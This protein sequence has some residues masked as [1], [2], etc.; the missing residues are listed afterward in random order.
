[1]TFNRCQA[2]GSLALLEPSRHRRKLVDD[3][4]LHRKRK[5]MHF[6]KDLLIDVSDRKLLGAKI[7]GSQLGVR[8]FFEIKRYYLVAC[9]YIGKCQYI[10]FSETW[11]L[12]GSKEYLTNHTEM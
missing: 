10:Y 3:H 5:F 8:T 7:K 1:M 4:F 6:G 11:K 12:T 2:R 9:P